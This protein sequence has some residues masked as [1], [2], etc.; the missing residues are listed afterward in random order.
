MHQKGEFQSGLGSPL[1]KALVPVRVVCIGLE[2]WNRSC[3]LVLVLV[4][5]RPHLQSFSLKFR[6]MCIGSFRLFSE[7]QRRSARKNKINY[8]INKNGMPT[9]KIA[10]CKAEYY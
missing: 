3:V 5:I 4:M 2:A 6:E 10:F 1:A 9:Y 8:F 7:Y